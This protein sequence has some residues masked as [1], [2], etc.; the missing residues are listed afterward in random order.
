MA[1]IDKQPATMG[2]LI[3]V[4]NAGENK[5]FNEADTYAA[6]WVEDADGSNKRCVLF[7]DGEIQRAERRALKNPDDQPK[8]SKPFLK[9]LFGL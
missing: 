8:L 2:R 7:T 4:E 1:Q 3:R 6:V 5:K 9:S